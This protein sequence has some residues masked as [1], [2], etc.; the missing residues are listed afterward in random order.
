MLNWISTPNYEELI[1]GAVDVPVADGHGFVT[2]Y[3]GNS[4]V[5]N[6]SNLVQRQWT[7]SAFVNAD[8]VRVIE[9]LKQQGFI[10]FCGGGS[11]T[12]NHALILPLLRQYL[13]A[14]AGVD[15]GGFYDCPISYANLIDKAARG[16]VTR[17][18][19]ALEH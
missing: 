4:N 1:T 2:E 18:S 12:Y 10:S 8:P 15:E 17:V 11:C 9:I 19:R 5:V 13:P 6:R 7:A 14:P 16:C 3:A